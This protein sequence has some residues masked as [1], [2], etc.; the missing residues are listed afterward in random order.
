MLRVVIIG[1]G[2]MFMNLIA[3]TLDANCEIV[4]VMRREMIK[5]SPIIRK[6]K[7]IIYFRYF[8]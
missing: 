4:G 8:F 7:D 3:G 6:I 1:Y 5:Y 2:D